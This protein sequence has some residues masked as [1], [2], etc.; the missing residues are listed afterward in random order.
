M[1][2]SQ[3]YKTLFKNA[4]K[5]V[6]IF[7]CIF[8]FVLFLFSQIFIDPFHAYF[9]FNSIFTLA[10]Y[11]YFFGHLFQNK[12]SMS[13]IVIYGLTDKAYLAYLKKCLLIRLQYFIFCI[14]LFLLIQITLFLLLD[15]KTFMTTPLNNNFGLII[16]YGHL[17]L[18]IF[19][20]RYICVYDER[21]FFNNNIKIINSRSIAV[22]FLSLSL[23]VCAYTGLNLISFLENFKE[24]NFNI[25]I[26]IFALSMLF[27][28]YSANRLFVCNLLD[29]PFKENIVQRFL[30]N[31]VYIL[32]IAITVNVL[33][34]TN[35]ANYSIIFS[36]WNSNTPETDNLSFGNGFVR[37][38]NSFDIT[39]EKTCLLIKKIEF[40]IIPLCIF[41][42]SSRIIKNNNKITENINFYSTKGTPL[43]NVLFTFYK[44]KIVWILLL[45]FIVHVVL[46]EDISHIPFLS[47]VLI[48]ISFYWLE[49]ILS[50]H[51]FTKYLLQV[52]ILLNS[53]L[54]VALW[55]RFDE[56]IIV[57][58]LIIIF[59]LIFIYSS[60]L[61]S[62]QQKYLYVAPLIMFYLPIAVIFLTCYQHYLLALLW[63]PLWV[64]YSKKLYKEFSFNRIIV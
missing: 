51:L 22:L 4:Y 32:I 12:Y 16:L 34:Y 29:K 36:N 42:A 30:S 19:G 18:Y 53:I 60:S 37:F 9:F 8:N 49:I 63:M 2:P 45:P 57:P 1:N 58:Y 44:R 14:F 48:L 56:F 27:N 7:T 64:L 47:L 23:L 41:I 43:Q 55:T 59:L 6:V 11:C 33:L 3:V 40:V 20:L 28:G 26:L 13:W 61:L 31:P 46:L 24:L 62:K 25:L 5:D 52:I 17:I 39:F 21:A 15:I 50:F 38:I 54:I 10:I 35:M